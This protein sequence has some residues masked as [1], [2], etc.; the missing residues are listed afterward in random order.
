MTD[1][2]WSAETAPRHEQLPDPHGHARR[3]SI[4]SRPDVVRWSGPSPI[5]PSWRATRGGPAARRGP[6]RVPAGRRVD[7]RRHQGDVRLHRQGRHPDRAA[8]GDDRRGRPGL[9]PAPAAPAVEGLVRRD[10]LPPRKPQKG[11]YRMFDQVGVEALG[12]DDPDLD[13]EVIALGWRFYESL[14][15]RQVR[16]LLNSL[17]EGE[18]RARFT[19]AVRVHLESHLGELSEEGRTDARP[20]PAARARFQAPRGPGG[21][22]RRAARGRPPVPGVEGALRPRVLAGLDALEIPYTVDPPARPRASTTTA[23]RRSSTPRTP[24]T[25]AQNAVGGGGRYDG[26]AEDHRWAGDRRHR[27]RTRRR[28]HPPGVRRRGCLRCT[29]RRPSTRS[30]STWS[31]AMPRGTSPTSS[32]AAGLSADR[33]FGG[34]SMKAQMKSADRSGARSMP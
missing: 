24:S 23:A 20:E 25:A 32:R 15:L 10:E 22:R 1:R 33:R 29:R 13:V 9:R 28:P 30:W 34:G 31:A 7:R 6:G 17:G 11:R 5:S 19:E 18:D 21:R 14:G 8:T 16:L 2:P 12:V 4:P 27:L 3:A 26:L